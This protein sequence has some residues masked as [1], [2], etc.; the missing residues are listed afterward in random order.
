MIAF[1]SQLR[2][3]FEADRWRLVVY[4][5][6]TRRDAHLTEDFDRH[7]ERFAWSPDSRTLYFTA[8]DAA[9]QPI[10]AVPAAGGAVKMVPATAPSTI[11]QVRP[12][13][14]RC[15]APRFAHAPGRDLPRGADGNGPPPR[16]PRQRRLPRR[17]RAAPRRERHL[18]GRRRQAACRRGSSSPPTSTPRRSTRCSSSST[19]GRRACGATAGRSAGTPRSSP[20]PAT[21][22]SRPT[23][24]A[25]SAGARSS[26]TTSP[27]LGR[28]GLRGRHA[29]DRLR[30]GAALRGEGPHRGRRRAPTAAT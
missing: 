3:G 25:P 12:T 17:L 30:R 22:C 5:R 13:G 7:V 20:T 15:R 6:R 28:Q 18:H 9:R 10:Y 11:S 16:H 19:A 4:D 1:R 21:W 8:E 26:S 2:A 27:G 24:A 23:R 29:G 14:G